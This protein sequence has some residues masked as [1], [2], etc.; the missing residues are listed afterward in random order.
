MPVGVPLHVNAGK[1]LRKIRLSAL[2]AGVKEI[3]LLPHNPTNMD[4]TAGPFEL[5]RL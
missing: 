3:K 5:T 2:P 1:I 4:A